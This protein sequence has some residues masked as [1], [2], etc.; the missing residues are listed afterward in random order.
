[1]S[2]DNFA[3]YKLLPALILRHY[4]H[5][6]FSTGIRVTFHLATVVHSLSQSEITR[7][8]S[9]SEMLPVGP[10]FALRKDQN[11]LTDELRRSRLCRGPLVDT[12]FYGSN[13]SDISQH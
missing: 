10:E 13:P 1:M 3:N 6:I 5:E 8:H 9:A 4:F 7:K 12:L 2:N 11:R